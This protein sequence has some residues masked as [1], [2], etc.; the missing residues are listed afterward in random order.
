M[1]DGERFFQNRACPYFPCHEGVPEED[2]NCLF[3]FCPLYSLGRAC[4]GGFT[5]TDGGIKSCAACTVPHRPENYD[6]ILA[7]YPDLM[8]VA[9]RTDREGLPHED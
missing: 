4:G 6:R 7:R 9:A 8:A 3:C 5:Y 2:F 1:R